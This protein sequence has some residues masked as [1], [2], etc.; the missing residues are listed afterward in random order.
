[1]G[2][3]GNRKAHALLHWLLNLL[4]PNELPPSIDVDAIKQ[5]LSSEMWEPASPNGLPDEEIALT[6]RKLC[7]NAKL[8]RTGESIVIAGYEIKV[9]ISGGVKIKPAFTR[10]SVDRFEII[11]LCAILT[12]KDSLRRCRQ[13]KEKK[14]PVLFVRNRRQE[15][16]SKQCVQV[17]GSKN[18]RS[19]HPKIRDKDRRQD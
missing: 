5:D 12:A 17:A 4:D 6:Y 13:C 18:F 9:P 7:H 2:F 15:Y 14:L 3:T 10:G 8:L 11:L 16:C 1:M 19:S